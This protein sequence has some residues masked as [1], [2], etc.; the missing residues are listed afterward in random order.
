M[1]RRAGALLGEY[2]ILMQAAGDSLVSGRIGH[3][4]GCPCQSCV[5]S[6]GQSG[7]DHENEGKHS[8]GNLGARGP[9]CLLYFRTSW[10]RGPEPYPSGNL[11]R[12]R[13]LILGG[14]G[15]LRDGPR[16][17]GSP[18]AAHDMLIVDNFARRR[19]HVDQS[20]DSLTPIASFEDRIEAWERGFGPSHRDRVGCIED[21]GS[22][23]R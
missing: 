16:R 18:I 1:G 13:I 15:Y 11:G 17:C 2:T 21:G 23:T 19:W 7:H 8:P 20:T 9:D 5:H 10:S 14:D 3:V 6:Q 4:L 12:C 22:S